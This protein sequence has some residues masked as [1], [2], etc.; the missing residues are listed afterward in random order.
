[1]ILDNGAPWGEGPRQATDSTVIGWLPVQS[2]LKQRPVR[3]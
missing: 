3:P 1:M 2:A